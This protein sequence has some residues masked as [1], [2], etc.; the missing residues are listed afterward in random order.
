MTCPRSPSTLGARDGAQAQASDTRVRAYSIASP[1]PQPEP[2]A[3][4]RWGQAWVCPSSQH[5]HVFTEG[6]CLPGTDLGSGNSDPGDKA[7]QERQ[8]L[9]NLHR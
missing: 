2:Q 6:L 1:V 5:S 9:I 3:W 8:M 4:G 7:A